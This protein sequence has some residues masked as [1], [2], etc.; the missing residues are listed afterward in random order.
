MHELL[1]RYVG[2][3][4][5]DERRAHALPKHTYVAQSGKYVL[6]GFHDQAQADELMEAAMKVVL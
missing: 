2:F 4:L 6:F 3:E 1:Y 5:F